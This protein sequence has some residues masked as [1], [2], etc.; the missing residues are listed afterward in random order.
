MQSK[1]VRLILLG[2]RQ[3]HVARCQLPMRMSRQPADNP[4]A[5]HGRFDNQTAPRFTGKLEWP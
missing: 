3:S 4:V 5:S 1:L 2:Y